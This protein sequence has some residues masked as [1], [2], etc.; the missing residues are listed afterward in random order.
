MRRITIALVAVGAL[1][2]TGVAYATTLNS[3]TAA[4]KVSGSAGSAK[5]PAP[6][7]QTVTL[8]AKPTSGVNADPLTDIKTTL[9]GVKLTTKGFATCSATTIN[10]AKNDAGCPSKALFATGPV[11]AALWSSKTPTAPGAPCDP[12]LDIWN[13]G[14]GKLTYFF[15]IP[16]GHTCAGLETG[17]VAAWTGSIKQSGSSVIQDTPL[18][19]PV[20]TDAGGLGLFSALG[21]ETL[22]YPKMTEKS[23]GKTVGFLASTSCAGGGHKYS[24]AFT[25]TNGSASS[26]S[27]VKGSAKC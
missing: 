2:A 6:I 9:A 25:A 8:T 20:S 15:K 11:T 21:S 23:G 18:P 22:K 13:A 12:V 27:T 7:G 17:A 14:G 19:P 24:V 26:T 1:I 5:A 16:A 10:T 4:I 3:Y